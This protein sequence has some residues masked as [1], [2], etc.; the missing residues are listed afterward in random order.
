MSTSTSTSDGTGVPPAPWTSIWRHDRRPWGWGN[1]LALLTWTLAIA[2]FFWKAVSLRE[3][4]FFF[5]ISE[6]NYP[7]RDFLAGELRSGRFARWHPGLY[8][9]L[10]LYSES[11]A[12]YFHPLKYLLYPWMAAWKAFN[13]D[14]IGS[15]WLTGLATYGW[16]RRHVG[17]S[18]ALTGASVFGLSG[19]VWAHLIHTSMVNALVSVPLLFWAV[20]AGWERRRLWPMALEA[21]AMA[22]QVFAGHLQDT[23]LTGMALGLYTL[24][25]ALTESSVRAGFK[26]LGMGAVLVVLGLLIAAVQWIPSKELLDRSPRAGV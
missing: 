3:A 15:V 6:I 25:R 24:Y 23:I 22:C 26:V 12:G 16:L 9:G 20:E 4:L 21:L 10:P 11:Q 18:G 19:F 5:D 17:P 7:Y 2:V 8:C 13:L 14:T 1:A